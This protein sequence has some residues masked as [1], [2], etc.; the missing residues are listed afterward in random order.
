MENLEKTSGFT[1]SSIQTD[2]SNLNIDTQ[3]V[4]ENRKIIFSE[5]PEKREIQLIVRIRKNTN[6]YIPLLIIN[7]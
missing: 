1:I 2:D 4:L 6:Q 5:N 3:V 7:S